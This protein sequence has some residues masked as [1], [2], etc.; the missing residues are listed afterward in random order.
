MTAAKAKFSMCPE[1]VKEI[2][3]TAV[4]V[5]DSCR[6]TWRDFLNLE[7]TLFVFHGSLFI[8]ICTPLIPRSSSYAPE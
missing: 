3:H 5:Q 1:E 6:E 4:G 7:V 8:S 2:F